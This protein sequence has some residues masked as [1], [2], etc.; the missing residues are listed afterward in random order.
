MLQFYHQELDSVT[1]YSAASNRCLNFERIE[2]DTGTSSRAVTNGSFPHGFSSPMSRSPSDIS[3][4]DR[5]K[6]PTVPSS[7]SEGILK[8]EELFPAQLEAR[9]L[10]NE[11]C[12]D[13]YTS[14]PYP[15]HGQFLQQDAKKAKALPA[16]DVKQR[17]RE[18]LEAK[19]E[20]S[21]KK[22]CAQAAAMKKKEQL[23]TK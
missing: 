10:E 15:L 17:I 9:V 2:I 13:R 11:H 8:P 7:H 1:Y 5:S 22:A 20:A 18:L 19:N 14:S 23:E 16:S 21:F 12:L 4:P 6:L 3:S